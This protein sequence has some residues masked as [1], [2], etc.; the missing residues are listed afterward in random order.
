MPLTRRI[1]WIKAALK[2][3]RSFPHQAQ[4][5]FLVAL[6]I[7]A[8]GGKA[9]SAKPLTGF[10]TGVMEVALRHRGEALRVVY[11]LSVSEELWVV[12]A[13]HKKSTRGIATPRRE[14]DLVRA[15]LKHLKDVCS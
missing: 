3:F 14:L 11:A 12:H 1:S 6:T 10:G 5:K 13:F 2:D 8:E 9:D 15:R 4:L 7:A